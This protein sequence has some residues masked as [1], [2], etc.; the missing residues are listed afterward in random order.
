[1][2]QNTKLSGLTRAEVEAAVAA[3]HLNVSHDRTSRSLADIL[4]ANLFTRFNF[5]ITLLAIIVLTVGSPIDALFGLV[6]IINSAIGIFQEVRAKRTL[7][8]L[9]IL[10]S[11][12]AHVMREGVTT[13][14]P[15]EQVVLG[16]TLKLQI[17]DQVPADG[18]I[19]QVEGLEIDESLL[20]GESEA[21]LKQPKDNVLSGSIVV[22]G[23]G[24]MQVTAVGQDAYAHKIAQQVKRFSQ[25]RS[26]LVAGTNK[27]LTYISWILLVVAPILVW[28]QIT[29]SGNGWQEAVIRSTSAIVGM[30][31]EGLV[32]LTSLAF[33][34]ATLALAKRKVLVQQ[35]PAVEGLARVDVICLDKTGT[36]TEGSVV[37]EQLKLLGKSDETTVQNV[38]AAF[39][40][41]PNSATLHALHDAFP[42]P[43]TQFAGTVPF[44]SARKWSAVRVAKKHWVM[45]APEMMFPDAKHPVR[46]QADRIAHSGKRVLALATCSAVPTAE[47]LPAD[48]RATAL[49][50]LSE[51]I[52]PDAA[53]TLDFF[54]KQGVRLIV[55][56]GDNPRT[57]GAIA[58]K[59][60]L[61]QEEPVD[62]RTLPESPEG[63]AKVLAS[64]SVFGR[65][66][67][68]QKRAIVKALQSQGHVVA[69][70]G[71][72]VND[73]LALK[74][75][76]IGIAM[77][78]GAA[79]TKAIAEL[80]L[81]D[82]QFARM[83]AVLAEGR[84][85]IANIERVA[86]LFLIKNVYSLFLVLAVT[87]ASMPY[88]FLPRHMTIISSLTIGIPA[89][90]LALA[91]NN[92]RYMPGFLKRVLAFAVPTGAIISGIIF[93]SY[94]VV[95]NSGG[96]AHTVSTVATTAVVMVGMWVLLCLARPL[97]HW[98]IGLIATMALAYTALLALPF[99]RDLLDFELSYSYLA[100]TLGLGF[101]GI[102]LIETAWRL[103]QRKHR[104]IAPNQQT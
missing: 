9:A 2:N 99:S 6:I 94:L 96:S 4:R 64:H 67:P 34:L 65:V 38:L 92:Q 29:R 17:G 26:E 61:A 1:M 27:L 97:R 30:I 62:A 41:E 73:A 5:L 45:G 33:M 78:N 48:L 68:D 40:A 39:A 32:L 15:I 76:D 51:K 90:F 31:P 84:R 75:A 44:S 82:N 80:V 77:G 66:M 83:P 89:F 63:L 21:V 54:A 8:K 7:D 24:F 86:N 104:H 23:A 81:L 85:V 58:G 60:G 56:S 71:D 101:A 12:V 95:D 59:V 52:R 57:V 79:A 20:T 49:I 22:A 55:I 47:A 3:G 25:A 74:D 103:V 72:G 46:K 70:T 98:K 36:L 19:L 28:G 37:F 53:K 43:E 16:D 35:L 102:C 50:V 88:P 87:I 69:M 10:N 13:D 18:S 91:P 100:L 14:I 42:S 93:I 11:P